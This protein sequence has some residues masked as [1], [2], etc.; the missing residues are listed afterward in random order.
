MDSSS[1]THRQYQQQQQQQLQKHGTAVPQHHQLSSKVKTIEGE[2]H[3]Y[4]NSHN[5]NDYDDQ[6]LQSKQQTDET[7]L[8]NNNNS[9]LS[10]FVVK[11]TMI[12]SIGG[13]LFGY[14][15]GAISSALP[16]L[17]ETF[18]LTESDAEYVVSILFVGGGI[19]AAC[20]GSICDLIGRQKSILLTDIIFIVGAT[21]LYF[22]SSPTVVIIGRFIVGFGIAVSGIADVSYL[23][24]IAPIEYR[25]A[26]VSVNEACISLGFL[27]AYLAGYIYSGESSSEEWRIIFGWAGILA[28]IQLLGMW[29]MPESPSWLLQH[30][31]RYDDYVAAYKQIHGENCIIP[32]NEGNVVGEAAAPSSDGDVLQTPT[33]KNETDGIH[34]S[35]TYNSVSPVSITSSERQQMIA[36]LDNNEFAGGVDIKKQHLQQQQHPI[37]TNSNTTNDNIGAVLYDTYQFVI[38]LFAKYRKQ[39]YVA[40]YLS[41]VQQLCGQTSVLNYAPII[42]AQSI[43][44]DFDDDGNG[45][46]SN[47]GAPKWSTVAIGLVKFAVTVI[48]IARIEYIGR[49]R[50]LLIGQTIIALGLLCLIVAFGGFTTVPVDDSAVVDDGESGN[51]GNGSG[52]QIDDLGFE[53]ALPGV[54]MVVS[55][56]SMSFGPLTWLLTSEL[57]PTHI[58]GRALGVST[59]VT[60]LCAS[61]VTRTF[62]SAQSV[63]GPSKVF[64]LYFV[65][66]VMGITFSYLGVPDTGGKT[67]DQVDSSLQNMPWWR[68]EHIALGQVDIVD[69]DHVGGVA[70]P[71]ASGVVSG[72]AFDSSLDNSGL[73]ARTSSY[74]RHNTPPRSKRQGN[75]YLQSTEMT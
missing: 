58:R 65:V 9:K 34:W 44:D 51:N 33:Q 17:I 62:L 24:E 70:G 26:I 75:T 23:H 11:M 72:D 36:P 74:T 18:D 12:A 60:Y 48:V 52:Y 69:F 38:S 31:G 8:S 43:N 50:L 14:D 37:D 56:Y 71:V 49:R 28:F 1:D 35:P 3:D 22:A 6:Q 10:F 7:S 32:A 39:S 59:I 67:V 46:A 15:M 68:F 41:V 40:L 45:S 63:L 30:H 20:G 25:G 21:I 42:F 54:L 55:G 64:A 27:L 5:D 57:Y 53:L 66:T 2:Q 16:Q 29:N 47:S 73:V 4:N 61:V 19:G 13:C